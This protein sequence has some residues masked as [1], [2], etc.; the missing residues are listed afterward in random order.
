MQK[1]VPS[2]EEAFSTEKIGPESY[3][4]LMD[5]ISLSRG[6]NQKYGTHCRYNQ[7][8]PVHRYSID[9]IKSVEKNRNEIGLDSLPSNSCELMK[10]LIHSLLTSK[11]IPGHCDRALLFRLCQPCYTKSGT[12]YP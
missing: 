5:E 4:V 3:A 8:G 6:L 1:F 9:D 12:W 2:L 10:I 7:D 11:R